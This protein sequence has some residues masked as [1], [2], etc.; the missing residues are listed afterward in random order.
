MQACTFEQ[1]AM[2]EPRDFMDAVISTYSGPQ[3]LERVR[4]NVSVAEKED[5]RERDW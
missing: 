3:F 2:Q 1:T 4:A 5:I